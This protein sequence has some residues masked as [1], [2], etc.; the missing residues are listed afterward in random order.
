MPTRIPRTAKWHL[1][2]QAPD[3]GTWHMGTWNPVLYCP[4]KQSQHLPVHGRVLWWPPPG[5]QAACTA[6][7]PKP[8]APQ[9]VNQQ[10][11]PAT[12]TSTLENKHKFLRLVPPGE[13]RDGKQNVLNNKPEA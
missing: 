12:I 10:E 8:P 5:P 3:P 13:E 9:A 7:S 1:L 6:W 2:C 4:G 11:S